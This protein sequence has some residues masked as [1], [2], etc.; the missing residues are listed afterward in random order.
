[1]VQPNGYVPNNYLAIITALACMVPTCRQL[2]SNTSAALG[3][4]TLSTQR[5]RTVVQPLA[6]HNP[7]TC[8]LMVVRTCY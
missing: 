4:F 8:G 6:A 3:L 1:M 7:E 5:L 2:A